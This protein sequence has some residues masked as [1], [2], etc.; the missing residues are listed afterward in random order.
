[1]ERTFAVRIAH[2]G[3]CLWLAAPAATRAAT[4]YVDDVQSGGGGDGSSASPF[5]TVQQA[6]DAARGGDDILVAGGTYAAFEVS[7]KE[8]R[9]FGGYDAG[10]TATSPDTP[11]VV[12]GTPSRPAVSLYEVGSSVLDGVPSTTLG[13]SGLVAVKPAS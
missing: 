6:I 4:L 7:L 1:M 2:L 5:G 13:V 9:L 12:E 11:S 8:V 3:A 10:F